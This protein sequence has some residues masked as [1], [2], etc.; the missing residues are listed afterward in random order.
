[1]N[2]TTVV[3]GAIATLFTLATALGSA[4]AVLRASALKQTVAVQEGTITALEK[5]RQVDKD[6]ATRHKA[7]CT[8]RIS[9]LEGRAAGLEALVA[10]NI[11]DAVA[12][13]VIQA[14]EDGLPAIPRTRTSPRK[15]T[16]S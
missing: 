11:A 6:E 9:A 5:A 10:A 12:R 14:L 8:E 15:R 16:A 7:E 2:T 1:M 4:V 13:A 3:L